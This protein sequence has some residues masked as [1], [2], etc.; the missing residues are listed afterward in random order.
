MPGIRPHEAK[1]QQ[2]RRKTCLTSTFGNSKESNFLRPLPPR[3]ANTEF[4]SV[5]LVPENRS[6][7]VDTNSGCCSRSVCW[8]LMARVSGRMRI[9][10]QEAR[11]IG[12]SASFL[13]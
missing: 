4:F 1:N 7:G 10:G 11:S 3:F 2:N 13:V 6:S 5:L 12:L 9:R 8:N